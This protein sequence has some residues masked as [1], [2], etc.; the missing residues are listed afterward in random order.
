[1]KAAIATLAMIAAT[2]AHADEEYGPY[3]YRSKNDSS[4]WV[5]F[6]MTVTVKNGAVDI[7]DCFGI[8]ENSKSCKDHY[9]IK[10]TRRGDFV[11]FTS[12]GEFHRLN[13]KKRTLRITDPDGVLFE[14]L[15]EGAEPTP[16]AR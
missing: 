8:S 5:T 14:G 1:M 3:R 9:S 10:A 6:S 2:V 16:I 15:K 13:T 11:E 7:R 12:G 4:S